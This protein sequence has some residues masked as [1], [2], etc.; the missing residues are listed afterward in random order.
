MLKTSFLW[1]TLAE[2]LLNLFSLFQDAASFMIISKKI[3]QE[4]YS[5]SRLAY[6]LLNLIK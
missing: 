3:P 6:Q 1:L 5:I 4:V 2:P